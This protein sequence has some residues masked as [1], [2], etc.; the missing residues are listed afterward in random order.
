MGDQ[1]ATARAKADKAETEKRWTDATCDWIETMF[2]FVEEG[3]AGGARTALDRAAA[4]HAKASAEDKA[5]FL[6]DNEK[7]PTSTAKAHVKKAVESSKKKEEAEGEGPS[8]DWSRAACAMAGAA[9]IQA[10][11]GENRSAARSYCYAAGYFKLAHDSEADKDMDE[12]QAED[13]LVTAC[14][15]RGKECARNANTSYLDMEAKR[16]SAFQERKYDLSGRE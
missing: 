3:D 11:N 10:S 13:E 14:D 4:A 9:A 8:E 16:D 2:Q 1:S 7:Y 15:T 12:K 5:T 6:R